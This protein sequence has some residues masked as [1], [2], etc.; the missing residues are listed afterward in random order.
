L[1]DFQITISSLL[2]C[3]ILADFT[4]SLHDP[5]SLKS[6]FRSSGICFYMPVQKLQVLYD[7]CFNHLTVNFGILNRNKVDLKKLDLKTSELEEFLLSHLQLRCRSV[8]GKKTRTVILE[9]AI[10]S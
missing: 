7:L 8:M 6:F 2:L 1:P 10:F 3:E 5:S 4:R 9:S